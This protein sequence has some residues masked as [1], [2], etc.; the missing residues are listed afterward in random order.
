MRPKPAP[1]TAE[2]TSC[3]CPL[4]LCDQQQYCVA[5]VA[6]DGTMCYRNAAWQ[7]LL[8]SDAHRTGLL[9]R[10]NV[11]HLPVLP[12]A[13][14]PEHAYMHTVHQHVES[15]LRGEREVAEYEFVCTCD[16]QQHWFRVQMHAYPVQGQRGV[17]IQQHILP[18]RQ[19][20][21]SCR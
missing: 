3:S 21:E 18:G 9:A 11:M 10:N 15:I 5:I 1:A 19:A 16:G 2:L 20:E 8:Q 12:M 17:L 6:T 13:F 4:R 14:S 7:H